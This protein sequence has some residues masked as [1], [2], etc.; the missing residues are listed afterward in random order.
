M[1]GEYMLK[2]EEKSR[3]ELVEYLARLLLPSGVGTQRD[4]VIEFLKRLPIIEELN[5]KE[6]E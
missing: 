2:L 6:K 5:P 4:A 3:D 1:K